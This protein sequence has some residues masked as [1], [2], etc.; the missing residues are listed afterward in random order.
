MKSPIL[1]VIA[2]NAALLLAILSALLSITSYV[3]TAEKSGLLCGFA[4]AATAVALVAFSWSRMPRGLR[5][6]GVALVGL[7]AFGAWTSASRLLG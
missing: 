5:F 1:A 2:F 3:P 4:L 7:A 6:L